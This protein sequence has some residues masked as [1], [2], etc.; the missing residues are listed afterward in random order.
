VITPHHLVIVNR[1]NY[2]V[3]ASARFVRN[4]SICT[5]RP[6][7]CG[8]TLKQ[9]G[10]PWTFVSPELKDCE[11]VLFA[12]NCC[13][14]LSLRLSK[15]PQAAIDGVLLAPNVP[16]RLGAYAKFG[17]PNTGMARAFYLSKI[18]FRNESSLDISRLMI[19]RARTL[20]HRES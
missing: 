10:W 17:Q 6:K 5:R 1:F 19:S 20:D 8:I 18:D 16:D 9:Q 4:V 2:F 3:S 7:F 12:F 11:A 14:F 13:S 15:Y